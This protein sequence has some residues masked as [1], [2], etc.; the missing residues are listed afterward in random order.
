MGK[1]IWVASYPKSGNTWL[2][3]FLNNYRSNAKVPAD[4]N[5]LKIFTFGG[6]SRSTYQKV[7][8]LPLD[9]LDDDQIFALTPLVHQLIAEYEPGPV[10]VKTHNFLPPVDDVPL[11]TR[12]LTGGAVYVI[13]N[14]LDL[15]VSLSS[16]YGLSL[17]RGID[18]LNN[19]SGSTAR[20]ET[21]IRQILRSWK[22]NVESWLAYD[23][24]KL[25]VVRYEDMLAKLNI[26][27]AKIVKFL[28]YKQQRNRL[29]RAINNS[30]FSVL[31]DQEKDRGFL[32]K[33]T[34]NDMLFRSGTSG[35]WQNTLSEEQIERIVTPNFDL[36]RQFDYLPQEYQ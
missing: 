28:G 25:L 19:P 8:K 29:N 20:N 14:P 26:T 24:S 4:I 18:F 31:Q 17:D 10:F 13:R 32:E 12:G 21:M 34:K 11:I 35:Q 27:F 9:N 36:M 15:V 16:H 3:I 6:S 5:N 33:S 23:Q 2:R 22:I 7:S 30:S 1:I